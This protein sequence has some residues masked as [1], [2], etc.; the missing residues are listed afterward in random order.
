MT[1]TTSKLLHYPNRKSRFFEQQHPI[2]SRE[3][4]FLQK[5]KKIIQENISNEQFNVSLLATKVYLSVSQL[6]RRLNA[7]DQES[8]GRLIRKIRMEYAVKLLSKNAQ[9]IAD[10]AYQVG[11]INQAHFCRSFKQEFGCPPTTYIKCCNL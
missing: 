2:Y 11:F 4:F 7:L 1:S 6:N 8:A 10:I 9:S 5:V 3:D